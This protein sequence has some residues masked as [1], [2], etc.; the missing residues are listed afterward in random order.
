MLKVWRNAYL[1][2]AVRKLDKKGDM[3]IDLDIDDYLN[4]QQTLDRYMRGIDMQFM[5]ARVGGTEYFSDNSSEI[6]YTERDITESS[7]YTPKASIFEFA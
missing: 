3:L 1:L 6:L 4:P 7:E 5:V 2:E